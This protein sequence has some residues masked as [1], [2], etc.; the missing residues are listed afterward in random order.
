MSPYKIIDSKRLKNACYF[1]VT[2]CNNE[3][4][5]TRSCVSEYCRVKEKGVFKDEQHQLIKTFFLQLKA[6][7]NIIK[8]KEEN[9]NL[10]NQTISGVNEIVIPDAL[11]AALLGLKITVNESTVVP[12]S[13]DLI[14]YVD[15]A[16]SSNPTDELK[17]YVFSLT[18]P[19][20]YAEQTADELAQEIKIVNNDVAL[21]TVVKRS[22]EV[23]E[24]GSNYPLE[25]PVTETL[26]NVLITLFAGVNH[27][28]TNYANAVIELVYPKDDDANKNL[29]NGVMFYEHKM[30]NDGEFSLDDIYFKDAFTK[31]EDKLNLAVNN[32]KV[33]C[34]TS[35][36]NNFS[37]DKEGNLIVKSIS[38]VN[39]LLSREDVCN[40]IYPIGSIY[41]SVNSVNPQTLFGG[42]WT[43]L[44]DR[45]LLGAGDTYAS[46]TVGGEK[47]HQLTIA[48]MPSHSHDIGFDQIWNYGGT[49]S[50]ATT[51]G[52][53]YGGSGYI[54][55]TG[56]SQPH[57]NMPPYLTVYM[58]KRTA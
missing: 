38:G 41:L 46:G 30:R 10:E 39:G 11:N 14:I 16:S 57:N 28:Y 49:T 20:K 24:T 2:I 4:I 40:L 12:S 7:L 42:S 9:M 21:S 25:T 22:V 26:E 6:S 18:K 34:I 45:F 15:K 56:G 35:K 37:L 8:R 17:R 36:N 29:L 3:K 19:L 51:T 52:G 55:K 31:T 13:N 58:W 27:V 5:R 47:D 53:P 50:I 48:E 33:D 23:G 44:K 43:P 1:F 54:S 32:V